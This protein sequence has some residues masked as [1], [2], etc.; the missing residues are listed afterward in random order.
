MAATAFQD[1][2]DGSSTVGSLPQK[3]AASRIRLKKFVEVLLETAPFPFPAG[4]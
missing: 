2:K 3:E 1:G 4:K